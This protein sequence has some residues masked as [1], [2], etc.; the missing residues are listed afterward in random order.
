MNTET[1]YARGWC[2]FEYDPVLAAW[3]E[4]AVH[5]AQK[6]VVAKEHAKWL[7][8][9]GTWFVGVN[10][11]PN[12]GSG[13]VVDGG[14]LRGTAVDFI[15][16][17]LGQSG[18]EWDRGQVSACYPQYPQPMET[19]SPT[20]FRFRRERDAAHIDGL[21][22][23]GPER[24]RHMR[25][26]HRFVLGIPMLEHSADA[27]PFVVW[28]GSHEIIR[29]AFVERFDNIPPSQWEDED[30]TEIYQRARNRVFSTCKRLQVSARP[31]EAYMI[32]RLTLHGIA[33]WA[34]SASAGKDGRMI[35][36]FRPDIGDPE[37]WLLAP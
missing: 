12:D 3:V 18:F 9:G 6:A 17:S 36:Y 30:V 21:L 29:A 5:W 23:E 31:G 2:R 16:Q 19:E 34:D 1:F 8:C 28:E 35:C 20:A 4:H 33:P 26:F 27:S 10:A 11:L 37:Q 24:R 25:E 32:H 13:A 22:P 7:R 14:P 15:H